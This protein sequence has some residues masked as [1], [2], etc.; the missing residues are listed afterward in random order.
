MPSDYPE[1]LDV[2]TEPTL[3]EET[4]LS[5]AGTGTRNHPQH[6]RDLGDAIEKI[7]LNAAIRSHDHSGVDDRFHGSKLL[8]ANTHEGADKDSS[9]LS[10][11]NT[12][13]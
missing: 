9:R 11:H 2:F 6:H 7:E 13:S 3:P 8:Q 12:L 1:S 10:L 4:P 5:Q